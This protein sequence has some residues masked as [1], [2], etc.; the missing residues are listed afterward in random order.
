MRTKRSKK[1]FV[2]LVKNLVFIV[3]KFFFPVNKVNTHKAH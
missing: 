1:T 3:V 2:P